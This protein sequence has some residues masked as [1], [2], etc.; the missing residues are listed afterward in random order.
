MA[1]HRYYYEPDNNNDLIRMQHIEKVYQIINNDLYK[2]SV[3]CPLLCCL[4]KAE[5]KELLTEIHAGS[6]GDHIGSSALE[7]K[8]LLQGFLWLAVIDDASRIGTTCEAS[9]K[10]SHRSKA[11]TQTS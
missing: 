10:F 9:Q 8:V 5:C 7:A 1:Y 6:Y 2:T 11:L 4:S 3:T